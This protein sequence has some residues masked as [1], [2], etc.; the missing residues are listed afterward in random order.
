MFELPRLFHVSHVVDDLDAAVAWYDEVFAPRLWQRSELFGT[1]IALLCVGDVVLMPMAPSRDA[2]SAPGRFRER[3]GER[4][5]SLALYVTSPTELIEHL[6]SL[7]FRLTGSAGGELS[8]PRDEIWTQPRETPVLLE[9][10]L[11]RQSMSAT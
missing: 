7:G 9:F 3:F 6:R 5:H 10:L 1:S 11:S 4:L 2:P 8:D